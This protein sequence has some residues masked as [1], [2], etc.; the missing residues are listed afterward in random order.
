MGPNAITNIAAREHGRELRQTAVNRPAR[1][2][3]RA[4]R[5]R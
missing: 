5:R 3:G 2:L 1:G 4:G